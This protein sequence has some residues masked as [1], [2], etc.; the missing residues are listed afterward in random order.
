MRVCYNII[1]FL[2]SVLNLHSLGPLSDWGLGQNAPVAP[3]FGQ[4]RRNVFKV[5]IICKEYF[6]SS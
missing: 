5:V 6:Q 2:N 3:P 4:P 1:M